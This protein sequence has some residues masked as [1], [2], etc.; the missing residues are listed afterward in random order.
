VIILALTACLPPP[1]PPTEA[2]LRSLH[3]TSGSLQRGL[4]GIATPAAADRAGTW[5]PEAED[6]LSDVP[7]GEVT[8]QVDP[9]TPWGLVRLA[10]N[11]AEAR[12][13]APIRVRVGDLDLG[14]WAERA[15]TAL[16][17]T[18]GGR[19]ITVRGVGRRLSLHL[20][21]DAHRVWIEPAAHFWVVDERGR[22]WPGL[23]PPCWKPEPCSA[24]LADPVQRIACEL[25]LQRA[26]EHPSAGETSASQVALHEAGRCWLPPTDLPP[27][28]EWAARLPDLVRA[29]NLGGEVAFSASDDLPAAAVAALLRP[30]RD[31]LGRLPERSPVG[32]QGSREPPDCSLGAGSLEDL[33]LA[34]G[35]WLGN[36]PIEAK[37]EPTA[38]PLT[39]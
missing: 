22:P 33:R 5:W 34:E 32:I 1:S 6:L 18:C 36:Q 4:R 26:E 20:A 17:P 15:A 27:S 29:F 12:R 13:V 2:E 38:P 21:G 23:G 30:L 8:L 25:A 3:L 28:T 7:L 10:L 16:R 24:R 31:S 37:S 19:P 9:S 11:A 14:A 39:P 35:Y